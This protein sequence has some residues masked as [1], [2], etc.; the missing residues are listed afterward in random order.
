[1][2]IFEN[3]I[4]G[5]FVCMTPAQGALLFRSRGNILS[6]RDLILSATQGLG[7]DHPRLSWSKIRDTAQLDVLLALASFASFSWLFV[8]DTINVEIFMVTIFRGLNFRGD[9]YSWV[10]VP[11]TVNTVA[12][13]SCVQIFVGVACPRKLAH[14]ENSAFVI[15]YLHVS[16]QMVVWVYLIYTNMQQHYVYW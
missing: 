3:Q 6:A 5:T 14:K 11:P 13:F 12:N 1:M 15:V 9:K 16:V 10:R 2:L 4:T 8:W 7:L